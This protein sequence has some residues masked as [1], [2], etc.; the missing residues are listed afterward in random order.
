M[1]DL[2]LITFDWV[3]ETQ[4]DATDTVTKERCDCG[5]CSPKLLGD[6]RETVT[7][8]VKRQ[9]GERAGLRRGGAIV[10]CFS[11]CGPALLSARY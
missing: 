2:T 1:N 9:G 4:P 3:P 6:A 11:P 7:K 8:T 10:R 5:D